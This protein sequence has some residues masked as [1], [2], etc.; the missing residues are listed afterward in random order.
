MLSRLSVSNLAVVEK[1]QAE[2]APGLNVL[3]GETGA[4]KSV[5]MGALELVFGARADTSVVREGA[6]EA[7]VEAVFEL[8]GEVLRGVDAILSEFGI[9]PSEVEG[10]LVVRRSVSAAGGARAWVNDQAV[11]ASTLRRLGAVLAD[12]HGPRANQRILEEGFQRAALDSF[13][14]IDVG[15]YAR[16][17]AAHESAARELER[18]SGPPASE[19]E[20]ETL[21]YQVSEIEEAQI[22]AEDEDL[23]ERH[24]AAAHAVEII[25]AAN[26]I[27][28]ALGGERSVGELLRVVRERIAAV[29]RYF[30]QAAEW[31]EEADEIAVRA[32]ELS[33]TVADAA[34]RLDGDEEEL[35]R[36]DRRLTDVKRLMRKYRAA[37]VAGL[38]GVLEAKRERLSELEGRE[39][40][41]AALRAE[42][43]AASEALRREG[44]V[45]R[46]ARAKAGERLAGAVTKELHGLGFL[47]ARFDV[48]VREAQCSPHGA[49][50]IEYIFEP[51]PGEGARPLAN[52]ASS[53]EAARV[54][55]A[56]KAALAAHDGTDL[57]VFDE[58]DAN[59]GG[60]TG[61][62]VGERLRQVARS[63]Q[64]VAITHLPQSA[65]Y[66]ARHLVASKSVCGGRTRTAIAS[67]DGEER[68]AEIARMLGGGQAAVAHA[69]VLL[70]GAEDCQPQ[71]KD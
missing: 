56:L 21:R 23:A 8:G 69:R 22:T 15:A 65:V 25:S 40:R 52:V 41:L 28:D 42:V 35:E 45:L 17:W 60:E 6:R 71:K 66:G 3:T 59:I 64:V 37:D 11:S 33:R 68:V 1:A 20:S 13:A 32:D 53:G 55:L 34:S 39:E 54:M 29:R 49:D 12:L 4:G 19:D 44:A 43:A 36:L 51:N 24:A 38:L 70:Q 16:A 30:P 26:E 50:R 46:E 31:A 58:I 9:E 63:H 14:R 7:R 47:K 5:L 18:L 48:A 62:A 10:E 27:T 61:R 57:L 2:F 67:V